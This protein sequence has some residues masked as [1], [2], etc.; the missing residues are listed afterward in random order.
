MKNKRRNKAVSSIVGTALLLGMAIAL[1][2]IVQILALSIPYNPNPP[3]ARLTGNVDGEIIYIVHH[4]GESLS[5]DTRIIITINNDVSYKKT[6][7]GDGDDELIISINPSS[8]GDPNL[9]DISERVRVEV[10]SVAYPDLS[11]IPVQIIIVDAKSNSIMMQS[12][13]QE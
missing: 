1:F 11:N 13:I 7:A 2:S 10:V 6:V 4:G 9:W 8:S 5:L 3:S 12:T